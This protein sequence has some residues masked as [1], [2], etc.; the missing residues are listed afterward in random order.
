MVMRLNADGTRDTTFNP[1]GVGADNSVAAVAL[2]PD[3]KIVLGGFFT[4]Y[5]SD[6][7]ASDMVM[8]LN[9]DGTRDTTFNPGGLGADSDVQA[10]AVQADGEIVIGGEFTRYNGDFA[11]SDMVMWLN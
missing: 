10:V 8:R 5:N 1:G 4:K 6:A 7:A 9:A 3:G 11:A 2:Q